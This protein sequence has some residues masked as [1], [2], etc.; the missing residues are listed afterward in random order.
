MLGIAQGKGWSRCHRN[1][2]SKF[3]IELLA[4]SKMMAQ[5]EV[6]APKR[7]LSLFFF[8]LMELLRD[9]LQGSVLKS[10]I[11]ATQTNFT[12]WQLQMLLTDNCLEYIE[13]SHQTW[14]FRRSPLYH[15]WVPGHHRDGMCKKP[16]AGPVILGG[17]AFTSYSC[18]QWYS[19]MIAFSENCQHCVRKPHFSCL[20]ESIW[21]SR[22]SLPWNH[23]TLTQECHNKSPNFTYLPR[24]S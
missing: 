23:L 11:K 6:T 5:H 2:G 3:S 13:F 10:D 24:G 20:P 1:T 17:G 16:K 9:F 22:A 18:M 21:V 12:C 8:I 19:K 15:W 4:Y 14:E 7:L